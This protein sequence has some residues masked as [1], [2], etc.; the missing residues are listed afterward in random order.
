MARA[1]FLPGV[2]DPRLID[3]YRKAQRFLRRDY[4][5]GLSI[6]RPRRA[7]VVQE[8]LAIC[9]HVRTKIP[10]E[11]L[12]KAQLFPR[13]IDGV[14]LDVI[15][16]CVH[17]QL[18]M[19]PVVPGAQVMRAGGATGTVGLI[20]V[21]PDGVPCVLTAA[22]VLNKTGQRAFQPTPGASNA[23]GVIRQPVLT[24]RVDAAIAPTS[25]RSGSNRP[26]GFSINL[27]TIRYLAAGETLTMVGAVSGPR[28]AIAYVGKHLVTYPNG[29]ELLME[30]IVLGPLN[31]SSQ[32]LSQGGDSG[33]VWF[34]P[35]TGT[36]VGLHVAGGPDATDPSNWAFACHIPEVFQ[37]LG[38]R[39]V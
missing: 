37:A 14:P 17:A 32:L 13:E 25:P 39:L 28:E 38:L 23:I 27:D 26:V 36:A 15:A 22:H 9:V 7:G 16:S 21:A 24:C 34:D 20:V 31:G 30:G 35:K 4:V 5:T 3:A 1:P 18:A 29:T 6:G 19:N 11:Q 2:V 8:Q 12:T 10:E 33:A